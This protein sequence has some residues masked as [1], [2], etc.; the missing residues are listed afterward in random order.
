MGRHVTYC[1]I[2]M[3]WQRHSFVRKTEE[4]YEAEVNFGH[5][6]RKMI[7][8]GYSNNDW[9]AIGCGYRS[10]YLQLALDWLMAMSRLYHY[11]LHV[12]CQYCL[13]MRVLEVWLCLR[14]NNNNINNNNNSTMWSRGAA[15]ILVLCASWQSCAPFR[16]RYTEWLMGRR[17]L[18]LLSPILKWRSSHDS[19]F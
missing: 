18:I 6:V 1:V 11:R 7:E 13:C 12:V 9:L 8:I 2:G 4:F 3:L 19:A 14:G 17:T 10:C 16:L 5:W 15:L